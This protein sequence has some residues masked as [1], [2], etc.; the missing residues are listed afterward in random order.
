MAYEPD[1]GIPFGAYARTQI[2]WAML[3]EMRAADPAGER[4]RVKIAKVR[5]A[6]ETLQ[7]R[8]GRVAT[9]GELAK[10]S[11]LDKDVVAE[12]LKLDE[13]VRTGTSFEAHFDSDDGRQAV[14]LTD[15]V[16]LPDHAA[17]R[18]E[19]REMLAR[20]LK[21]LPE[22]MRQVIQGIYLEDRM[23]KDIAAEMEVSHA[24]VSKLRRNALTLMREA[25]E[26]WESGND[27]DRSTKAK[28]EF[29]DTVFADP[30]SRAKDRT[31]ELVSV[32]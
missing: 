14:D 30:R 23:V 32:S 22:A 5:L 20:V 4:G 27:G 9:V 19:T 3:D 12:M 7:G 29:F 28:V 24:Y 2:N 6:A 16:I 21:A 1:R 18:S 17:E 25:M 13:M 10:E 11:G 26:A 15:S 8:L 31:A